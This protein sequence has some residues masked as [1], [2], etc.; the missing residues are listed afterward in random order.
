M[1]FLRKRFSGV[2]HTMERFA[3]TDLRYLAESGFWMNTS[4][5]AISLF[6]L[7]LYIVF[8][9]FLPRETYGV[10][11]YFLSAAAIIGTLTLT[12]MNAAVTRA[13]ANGNDA[14]L[15]RAVRLQLAAG[16]LPFAAGLAAA[17]YYL[18][19]GN[20]TFSLAF[21]LIGILMPL[22][23][24]FNTYTAYLIG[25]KTFARLTLYTLVQYAPYYA[26]LALT[27]VFFPSALAL[28]AVNVCAT[29]LFTFLIYRR[30]V[31]NDRPNEPEDPATLRYG[32]NLSVM[33]AFPAIAAQLDAVLAFQFLGPAGL[34]VYSFATAIPDRL[35]SL[36]KFFPTAAL[37]KFAEHTD[38]EIRRS[39]GP[40]LAK[41]AALAVI[42]AGAYALI[43]PL[44][45]RVFFPTYLDAVPYS[46]AYAFALI[47]IVA[48]VAGAALTAKART[49]ALYAANIASP[50]LGLAFQLA[51]V[52]FFGLWGLIIGKV[53]AALV[54]CVIFTALLLAPQA[55]RAR[56]H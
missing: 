47:L 44:F 3:G 5:V 21:F 29:A 16:I 14:T 31:R 28:L 56:L 50:V 27:A 15:M 7:G 45:F 49:K 12:G 25:K 51:G 20:L 37:P 30:I 11:Q 32:T 42:F 35:G 54:A 36:F 18:A 24:A 46:Q 1:D 19:A 43:V 22:G 52:L 6:S 53:F 38:E 8:A 9:N 23:N 17:L 4:S 10:Y 55:S 33:N 34:A 13:V 2:F 41:L 26:L 40:K 48:N 39:I